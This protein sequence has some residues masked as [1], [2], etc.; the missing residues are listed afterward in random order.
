MSISSPTYERLKD[1][2]RDDIITGKLAAG[3]RLTMAEIA[4]RYKVSHMPVR[5][6]L[7]ALMGEGLVEI[8]PNRGARVLSLDADF[9]ANIFD[10]R[11]AI[12]GLLAKSVVAHLTAERLDRID[13]KNQIVSAAV[14]KKDFPKFSRADR[15]FHWEIFKYSNN[16]EA[17]KIHKKYYSLLIALRLKFKYSPERLKSSL[18]EHA[19]IILALKDRNPAEVEKQVKRHSRSA[20]EYMLQVLENQN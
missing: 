4:T 9:I 20:K 14:Q 19:S 18:Q 11:R 5:E 3:A 13:Q 2:L 8:I 6:A 10:I 7:Q 1:A 12:E 17:L 15:A 16:K